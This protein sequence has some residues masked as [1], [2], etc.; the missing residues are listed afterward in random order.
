M[1]TNLQQEQLMSELNLC[2]EAD[3]MKKIMSEREEAGI[4]EI[5]LELAA[6]KEMFLQVNQIVTTQQGDFDLIEER[7]K[8]ASE[9]TR[10][11]RQQLEDAAKIQLRFALT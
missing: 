5:N 10:F 4:T 1:D 11:G 3:I 6:V 7:T 2:D 8:T 9:Q